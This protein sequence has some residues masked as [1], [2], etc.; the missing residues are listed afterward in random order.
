MITYEDVFARCK[1]LEQLKCAYDDLLE[2]CDDL[3]EIKHIDNAY[4]KEYNRR[5]QEKS[6]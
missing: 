3:S 2:S 4:L 1:D 6:K 5:K